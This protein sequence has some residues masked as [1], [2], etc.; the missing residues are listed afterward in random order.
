MKKFLRIDKTIFLLLLIS[1]IIFPLTALG[2]GIPFGGLVTY[3]DYCIPT[4]LYVG[5]HFQVGPPNPGLVI[6]SAGSVV[7]PYANLK[8]G[9]WVLGLRLAPSPCIIAYTPVGSP[10]FSP[11]RVGGFT[12]IIGT[13]L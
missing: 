13:S 7:Y 8:V 2:V 1:A 10:I 3:Q 6:I 11:T 5:I 12:V 9:S 4:S